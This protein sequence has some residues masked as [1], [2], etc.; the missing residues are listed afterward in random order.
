[1]FYLD[2]A[3][4]SLNP[5]TPR[6]AHPAGVVISLRHKE[7]GSVIGTSDVLDELLNGALHPL[8]FD[9][10]IPIRNSA[11]ERSSCTIY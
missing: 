7:K 1:M 3:T 10:Q 4:R 2:G 5:C 9:L 6:L 8:L 11:A